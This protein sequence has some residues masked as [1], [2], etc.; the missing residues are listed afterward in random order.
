MGEKSDLK[1]FSSDKVERSSDGDRY[2]TKLLTP[3]KLVNYAKAGLLAY[4]NANKI[5]QITLPR[6]FLQWATCIV[7]AVH[8]GGYR[9]SFS[10]TSQSFVK[11]FF[12]S[13]F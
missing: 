5:S 4:G 12:P 7:N 13:Y 8:S 3:E 1:R 6:D 9:V 10:L 11:T 2:I